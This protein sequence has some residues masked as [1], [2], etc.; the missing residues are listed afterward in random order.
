MTPLEQLLSDSNISTAP[1]AGVLGTV[2]F[3]GMSPAEAKKT[4]RLLRTV[5]KM[6]PVQARMLPITVQL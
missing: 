5:T 6:S 3:E 2:S 4:L 1:A